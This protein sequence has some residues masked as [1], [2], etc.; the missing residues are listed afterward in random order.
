[1]SVD[2]RDGWLFGSLPDDTGREWPIVLHP[3][4]S[5]RGPLATLVPNLILHTTETAGYVDTLKYPSQWQC[6]E[7]VIGQHIKL[8]LAGDAVNNWDSYA[9]QIEMVGR[10]SLGLWLPDE[11]TLG[12]TVALVAWLHQTNRIKTGI[13]RPTFWPTILDKGPQA[14]TTYYRRKAGLWP[15]TPGVYGHV[16]I[17]DNSHW[18]PGSFNYPVFFARVKKALA[19]GNDDVNFDEYV[20]GWK[21]HRAGLTKNPDWSAAKKFGWTAR[22]EAT[23]NPKA[24]PGPAGPPGPTGPKGPKG[25]SAELVPGTGLRVE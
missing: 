6:G 10:S 15:D 21:A 14:V 16:D 1:M 9:Q 4:A 17:P 5:A 3:Q 24:V 7:G 19:G 22:E 13:T 23:E 25:D 8:G 20:N 18:D 12:P 2:I 11:Q